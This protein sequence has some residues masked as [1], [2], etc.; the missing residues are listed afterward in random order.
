MSPQ[1]K[2]RKENN[3]LCTTRPALLVIKLTLVVIDFKGLDFP[4]VQ[5]P[6]PFPLLATWPL[7]SRGHVSDNAHNHHRFISTLTS[8]SACSYWHS[9]I[10][11]S[12]ATKASCIHQKQKFFFKCNL[13]NQTNMSRLYVI[14]RKS[15]SSCLQ[16]VEISFQT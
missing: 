2:K 15:E 1:K 14:V 10:Y 5:P 9:G 12:F 13:T 11:Y 6:P 3:N 4:Q 8:I 7:G 16:A